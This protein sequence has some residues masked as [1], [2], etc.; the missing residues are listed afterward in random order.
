MH[1]FYL[2]I[3]IFRKFYSKDFPSVIF[4][5]LFVNIHNRHQKLRMLTKFHKNRFGNSLT[6]GNSLTYTLTSD[7]RGFLFPT[8]IFLLINHFMSVSD[9]G[10]KRAVRAKLNMQE[11]KSKK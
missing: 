7:R 11:K 6:D 4:S 2:R 3:I 9:V 8:Y 5:E 1:H 10:I